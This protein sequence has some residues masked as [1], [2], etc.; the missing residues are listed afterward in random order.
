MII[1][2]WLPIGHPLPGGYSC[3]RPL[4][5][6]ADWQIVELAGRGRALLARAAL[7][8]RWIAS[9][10]L[11]KEQLSA[12]EFGD[13]HYRAL[14]SDF[15]YVLAPA[16]EA[17]SPKSKSE[18][19]AFAVALKA[20]RAIDA[21][22]PLQDAIFAEAISRLL[23]TYAVADG[24]DDAI[25][26]GR[27]LTGGANIPA[28]S[29]RPLQTLMSWLPAPQLKEVL[30]TAGIEVAADDGAAAVDASTP[31]AAFDLPGRP[32]LAAFFNE[33]VVDIVQ[34]PAR[35]EALGIGFP[36]AVLLQGP[37]GCGKTFAVE[38]LID[39]L[40]WPSFRIDA[41]SVASPYIHETSRKVA[42]VFDKAM[43]NAPSVL[44]ID[45]MEAFL[46]DRDMGSS[47]HRV[48]EVAE[49]LR[50]IP[51]ATKRR[52]FIVAMT[53]R[54]DMI[55]LAI[56]RRGRF[57]HIIKVSYAGEAEVLALL[58]SLLSS[59]PKAEDVDPLP[60]AKALT[61]RPLSDVTFVV[62]DAARRAA[63]SGQSRISQQNLLQALH[64]APAI[65]P[66]GGKR[67]PIGFV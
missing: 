66:D 59:L 5:A 60:L 51:E 47:H 54:I 43:E 8:E 18:A 14:A 62:R 4:F 21:A 11:Y 34:N 57:D 20:T 44:V 22:S 26:L 39:Y 19:L 49:F 63:K 33:H 67:N 30:E 24:A 48:E 9:G 6:G 17:D 29:V 36:S 65:D 23:P 37:P 28:T 46:A 7:A 31:R 32:E 27:W 64:D 42:A 61:A 15:H 13:E 52:V 55:D 3:G 25:V 2:A 12:L 35:Y 40:G 1:D 10:L 53:N 41:S 56:L 50:K 38:R 16:V 45:E 58:S